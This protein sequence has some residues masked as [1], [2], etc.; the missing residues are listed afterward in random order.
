MSEITIW[1]AKACLDHYCW[2]MEEASATDLSERVCQKLSW[3]AW[4]LVIQAAK[5]GNVD[6][7]EDS[8][9]AML[10]AGSYDLQK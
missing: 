7:P 4:I 2:M 10:E 5:S 6:I 8:H 3:L 9:S 1:H